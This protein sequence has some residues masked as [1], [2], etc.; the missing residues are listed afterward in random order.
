MYHAIPQ[1]LNTIISLC[2]PLNNEKYAH[3]CKDVPLKS[4]GLVTEVDGSFPKTGLFMRQTATACMIGEFERQLHGRDNVLT[5]QYMRQLHSYPPS[6]FEY[7][8]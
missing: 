4:L 1:L 5:H 7:Y 3:D 2:R 8:H 6:S